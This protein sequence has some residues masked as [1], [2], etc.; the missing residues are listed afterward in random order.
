MS[1]L[2]WP[3]APCCY[4]PHNCICS[5]EERALRGWF[6]GAVRTPMSAAHRAYCLA[7][8][9]AAEGFSARDFDSCSDADLAGAV[10]SS[11]LD[12]ARHD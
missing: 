5:D 7:Q 8:L 2:E 6:S 10:L 11:W 9:K 4:D 12:F 3:S 1:T